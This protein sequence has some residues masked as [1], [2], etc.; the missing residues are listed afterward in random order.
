MKIG[1]PVRR[2]SLMIPGFATRAGGR[3][4]SQTITAIER[5]AFT[6]SQ[7]S[8]RATDPP[9]ELEPRT[10]MNPNQES[11][12]AAISPSLLWLTSTAI[13]RRLAYLV[14]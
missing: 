9:R 14:R 5:S 8:V 1:R 7:S 12:P 3:G 10:G 2:E 4:P 13:G 6:R 11:S